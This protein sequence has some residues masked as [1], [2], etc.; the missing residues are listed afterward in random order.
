METCEEERVAALNERRREEVTSG[1]DRRQ[2]LRGGVG[3]VARAERVVFRRVL[4]GLGCRRSACAGLR[5]DT[6][7]AARRLGPCG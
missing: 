1:P 6:P 3:S 5:R 7:R 4:V 2:V